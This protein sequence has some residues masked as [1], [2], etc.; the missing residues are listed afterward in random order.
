MFIN[1]KYDSCLD[2]ITGL[3]YKAPVDNQALFGFSIDYT[4]NKKTIAVNNLSADIKVKIKLV[5]EAF[6]DLKITYY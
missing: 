2:N 1:K 6:C 4:L 5:S 3:S